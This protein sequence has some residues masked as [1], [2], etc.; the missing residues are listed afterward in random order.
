MK[1]LFLFS[2]KQ[3]IVGLDIKTW[4]LPPKVSTLDSI[5]PKARE[6]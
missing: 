3:V 6:T 1:S 4:G 5:S 2:L